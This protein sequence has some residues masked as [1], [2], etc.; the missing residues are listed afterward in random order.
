MQHPRQHADDPMKVLLPK[1]QTPNSAELLSLEPY[2]MQ[3]L[4]LEPCC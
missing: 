4:E 3:D 1:A 2:T